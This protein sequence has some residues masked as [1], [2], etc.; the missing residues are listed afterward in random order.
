MRPRPTMPTVIDLLPSYRTGIGHGSPRTLVHQGRRNR[1][2]SRTGGRR[3][4]RAA[5]SLCT[6]MIRP[7]APAAVAASAMG[8]TSLADAGGVAGV[9]DHR[10]VAQS[11]EHRDGG[12]G[13]GCCGCTVSK[14][15]MPRSHRITCS[16]PPAMM[17]S[18]LISSSWRVLARPRL[19]R[20][21]LRSWPSSLSSS[22][23][24]HVPGAHLDDVHIFKA[25]GCGEASMISV[26]MGR[27]VCSL[28]SQQQL[29]ALA[30]AGP[31][32]RRGRCGA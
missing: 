26:T 13:P 19:R 11:V 7:S 4:G 15:R 32:R 12:R 16:L 8:C 18:A 24:L 14:V 28:A 27:P 6:S 17:Y 3:T 25:G 20:T 29:D 1:Q 5:G 2:G 23:V 22:K 31:G 21:G 9:D 10:Q 30:V